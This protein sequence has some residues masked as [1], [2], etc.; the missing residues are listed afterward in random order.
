MANWGIKVANTGVDIGTALANTLAMS[1]NFSMFK[2][3][4]DGT[5]YGTL[6]P[7]QQ[8]ATVTFTHNLGYVPMFWPYFINPDGNQLLFSNTNEGIEPTDWITAEA[9]TDTIKCSYNAGIPWNQI[10]KTQPYDGYNTYDGN[11]NIGMVGQ[12]GGVGQSTGFVFYPMAETS[13]FYGTLVDLPQGATIATAT[14]SYGVNSKGT[15]NA[16]NSTRHWL[17]RRNKP[18]FRTVNFI[19]LG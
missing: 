6:T 14:L 11:Y 5:S 15:N 17:G 7:G 2:L 1:S 18:H 16:S 9:G 13:F 12:I 4:S 3:H 10:L 8:A 19:H